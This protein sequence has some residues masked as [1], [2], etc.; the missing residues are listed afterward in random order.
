M[1]ETIEDLP[2]ARLGALGTLPD[3]RKFVVFE[4]DLPHSL[5]RVWQALANPQHLADW[6][7]G[8]EMDA[9]AGGRFDIWFGGDCEGPAHVSGVV[10]RFEPPSEQAPESERTAVLECGS[11]RY[12]LASN[13]SSAGG[14]RLVFTDVLHYEGE[15]SQADVINSVLG[16]WH[17]YLDTLEFSLSGGAY[18]PRGE[19]EFDYSRVEIGGR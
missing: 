5:S 18:D 14:C 13:Q 2:T 11:M 1:R 6:F 15:R 9:R 10:S 7:P 3:G 12:E 16:G 17:K 4:R 8:F 19:P